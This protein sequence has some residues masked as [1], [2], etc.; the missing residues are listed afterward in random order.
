ADLGG[1]VEVVHAL[2]VPAVDVL[3]LEEAGGEAVD[4]VVDAA[5]EQ[6]EGR[7]FDE[8]DVVL[9]DPLAALDPVVVEADVGRVAVLDVL[10]GGGVGGADQILRLGVARDLQRPEP[11]RGPGR[12]RR[13]GQAAGEPGDHDQPQAAVRH[14]EP[15][16]A[17]QVAGAKHGFARASVAHDSTPPEWW[18]VP[19]STPNR[20]RSACSGRAIP[21]TRDVRGREQA[22]SLVV[23]SAGTALAR[24]AELDV[25][26]T[27]G[28]SVA[29]SSAR[30]SA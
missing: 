15:P 28:R 30:W 1:V 11:E 5:P 24:S 7:L 19:C 13:Q 14:A 4:A 17:T 6:G 21:P 26:P 22:P 25:A 12:S 27:S 29:R 16:A 3:L 2:V 18:R 23:V 20:P 10:P 9:G 8:R